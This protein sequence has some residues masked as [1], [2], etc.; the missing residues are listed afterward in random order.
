MAMLQSTPNHTHTPT[1]THTH[2]HTPTHPHLHTL[3]TIDDNVIENS[4]NFPNDNNSKYVQTHAGGV[5]YVY[6]YTHTCTHAQALICA[7]I[8]SAFR[9]K[10]V[11]AFTFY[12]Y[13]TQ[14]DDVKDRCVWCCW[15]ETL[16]SLV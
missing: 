15:S 8:Y 3:C 10:L 7:Y 12:H 16:D 11:L 5:P 2:T 4:R 1:H 6:V 9:S 13:N 14:S